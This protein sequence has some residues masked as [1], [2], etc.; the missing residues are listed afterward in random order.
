MMRLIATSLLTLALACGGQDATSSKTDSSTEGPAVA[1][2]SLTPEKLGELGAR[3]RKEPTRANELLTQQG[4]TEESFEQAI[5]NVT[6]D[7]E[8]SKRYAE[9]YRKAG[10]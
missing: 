7:P 6:E 9:S 1:S 5:R 3:I 10:V 2:G 4:L 8:A